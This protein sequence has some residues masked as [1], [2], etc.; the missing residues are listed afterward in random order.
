MMS[1]FR[2][3]ARAIV[4][5]AILACASSASAGEPAGSSDW[6]NFMGP[7]RD[8][9]IKSET[10]LSEKW[11]E[12][13][14]K[15]LWIGDELPE[16]PFCGTSSPVVCDGRV[17]VYAH[18]LVPMDGI[19][20]FRELLNVAGY[21]GDMPPD[22]LKAVDEVRLGA[23][24]KTITSDRKSAVEGADKFIDKFLATLDPV[25]AKKYGAAIRGRIY[26]GDRLPSDAEYE[27]LLARKDQE[28]KTRQEFMNL[29]KKRYTNNHSGFSSLTHGPVSDL[30]GGFANKV[31]ERQVYADDLYCLD[32]TTGNQLW[33][34]TCLGN[35]ESYGYDF[36]CS[37][38]PAVSNGKVY[39][40]GSGGLHCLDA[41]SGKVV[42]GAKGSSSSSSAVVAGDVVYCYMPDLSAFDTK[43]GRELWREPKARHTFQTPALWV[44]E[45]KTYV[46]GVDGGRVAGH[47]GW[48]SDAHKIF[49]LDAGTGKIL[50]DAP[51]AGNGT[52]ASPV[53]SGDV[54]ALRGG[55]FAAYSLS[56][57]KA[58]PLWKDG[59][60]GDNGGT[61]AVI[62]KDHIFCV[63][64]T[65][66]DL[67][68]E[69]LDLKDG[70]SVF[71]KT[72][73]DGPKVGGD[74]STP[75]IT[76]D[77]IGFT[78]GVSARGRA[79]LA[80]KATP[81]KYEEVGAVI[82]APKKGSTFGWLSTVALA[83]GR[84]YVRLS[85]AVACYDVSEAG[86]K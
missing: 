54:V 71:K 75:L 8:G 44:H 65:Y 31:Y 17:Y 12:K 56:P 70:R 38:T 24:Y 78:V 46:L 9:I 47:G 36:K 11:P 67:F 45:G 29:M 23:E 39:L 14:P 4:L 61:S 63:G 58:T 83:E 37:G 51:G 1:M 80:F 19:Y 5:A 6:P 82:E 49:C 3:K 26:K 53:V 15:L 72:R 69:A 57:E 10:K 22:L 62:Y 77:G 25:L 50:W 55:A 52:K 40:R 27:W 64:R 33:K 16:A 43:T 86:N 41:A 79:L 34:Q 21:P 84:L 60:L 30:G 74:V 32:A 66:S 20:P 35:Y 2:V 42:W 28:V 59:N 48:F 81:D 7:N 68:F 13:G 76:T 85:D 73:R 18:T